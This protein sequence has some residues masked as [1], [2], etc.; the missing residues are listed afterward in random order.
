MSLQSRLNELYQFCKASVP[1]FNISPGTVL[2]DFLSA[3]AV[4]LSSFEAYFNSGIQNAFVSTA[5]GS[6]LDALAL[7]HGLTRN[8]ATAATGT[9]TL[10]RSDTSSAA[11]YPSGIIV[12]T[13]NLDPTTNVNF[14]TTAPLNFPAG[15]ATASISAICQTVGGQ[16]NAAAGSISAII[17]TQPG[18][19]AVTNTANMTGGTN[20]ES[21]TSLRARIFGT[22]MP[23]NSVARINS[24]VLATPGIFSSAT[25]DQQDGLGSVYTY[26][27]D[28]SGALS[29]TL[30]AS[31]QSA[32]NSNKSLGSTASVFAPTVTTVNVAYNYAAQSGFQAANVVAAINAAIRAYF[33]SLV[34][35][36]S[37]RAYDISSRVIGNTQGFTAVQGVLDF[38]LTNPSGFQTALPWQL[39]VLGTITPTQVAN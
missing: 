32:I 16:G 30:K 2:N 27:C 19:S 28:G 5:V 6:A 10:T 13:V 11:N 33:N 4:Q 22:L 23:Q 25:F 34:I 18:L 8:A 3:V 21:D 39:F 26:A 24:G 29:T 20:A 17:S 1:Q 38:Q 15:V 7:D 36:Q 37:I 31:V 9:I 14:V 12:S 35:G